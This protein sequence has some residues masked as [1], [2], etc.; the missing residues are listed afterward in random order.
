MGNKLD[1]GIQQNVKSFP[2]VELRQYT[3]H[4]GKRDV[5]IH[6]FD[7][8]FIESQEAAGIQVIGQFRDIDNS[9]RFVWMRGF[10]DMLRRAESLAAFY[11]GEVWKAHREVANDTMIDSDNVLLLRSAYSGS[12]FTFGAHGIFPEARGL[13]VAIIFYLNSFPDGT[14]IR[15]LEQQLETVAIQS[16]A[17]RLALLISEQ[18]GNTFPQLPVR[19]GENVFVHF[20]HFRD[21]D[22]AYAQ[23]QR[24]RERIAEEFPNFDRKPEVLRLLP[25]D[26][27]RVPGVY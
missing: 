3:L 21:V 24:W 7:R 13:A 12:E 20:L 16:H 9:D 18:S 10:P 23:S 11:T 26:R 27:S 8:E 14:L 25:T 4:P 6:L 17:A 19:E 2:I 1:H 5:L 22:S 15:D